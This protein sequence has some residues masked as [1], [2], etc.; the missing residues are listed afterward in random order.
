MLPCCRLIVIASASE[1]VSS[2][3]SGTR[4][5]L[6]LTRTHLLTPGTQQPPF[7]SV[8]AHSPVPGPS[9]PWWRRCLQGAT[10]ASVVPFG[11]SG[12]EGSPGRPDWGAHLSQYTT[13][14]TRRV[15]DPCC[16]SPLTRLWSALT[17][18]QPSSSL[19]PAGS[20]KHPGLVSFPCACPH[21]P[22]LFQPF[23]SQ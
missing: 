4:T 8:S 12:T 6:A 14:T 22:V 1:E 9:A 2:S 10:R 5:P 15:Q 23:R 3:E 19:W 18:G 16:P 21:L 13:P 20:R 11:G 7:Y 17:G